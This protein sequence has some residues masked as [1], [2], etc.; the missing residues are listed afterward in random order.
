MRMCVLHAVRWDPLVR[1]RFLARS[2][3]RS[4]FEFA[5]EFRRHPDAVR[6]GGVGIAMPCSRGGCALC[7]PLA[8]ALVACVVHRRPSTGCSSN[9]V[10]SRTAPALGESIDRPIVVR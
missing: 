3:M 2:P 5:F 4:S 7:R 6:G 1:A 8:H 10:A 9:P